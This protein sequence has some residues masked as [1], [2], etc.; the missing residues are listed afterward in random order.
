MSSRIQ[1][2]STSTWEEQLL[3]VRD[4]TVHY[5]GYLALSEVSLEVGHREIVCVMGANGSGKSTLLNA[6][7]GLVESSGEILSRAGRCRTCRRTSGWPSDWP[8]C[9]SAGGCFPT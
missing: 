6:V 1:W 4:L 3:S 5:G 7:S 2:S 8:T 9:S